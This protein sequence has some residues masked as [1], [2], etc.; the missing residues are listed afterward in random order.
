MNTEGNT[1]VHISRTMTV[2]TAATSGSAQS[3]ST[4][5]SIFRAYSWHMGNDK[6]CSNGQ[7]T[8]DIQRDDTSIKAE[9]DIGE[10]YSISSLNEE[11]GLEDFSPEDCTQ[12]STI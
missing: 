6:T 4:Y 3:N 9:A 10:E 7:D 12:T 8:D 2:V 5:R 1:N 11:K